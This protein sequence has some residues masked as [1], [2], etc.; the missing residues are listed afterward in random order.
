MNKKETIFVHLPAYRDPELVPTIKSALENAKYPKRIHFGVCRQ[1]HPE[2]G[3]DN[4]D[5]YK[6][7]KRFNIYECLYTEAKGLPWAR[8]VINEQLMGDQDYILQLDSH[9]RFAK[10][11]DVTLIEMHNQREKQGYKPIL[12]AYLPLYTP[13]N[14]PGG[15]TMEPWQQ[16]FVCFYPHGT[17]FIRPGLLTGWQDMTEAPFSRFLSGHFC[18]ARTEWA[19]EIKHDP[20]IY[21]SGEEINLTVR[22]YTHGYDMFHPHK[23]VVWH[24]TMRE[25]RSGMLKWDDDAKRGVDWWNKQNTAR[26]KIR[27]L[28]RVEDNGF[29]LTGYDLG[30]TR[31]I[32][33]YEAYAGVNFKEKSVQ[34]YTI[35]NG[36]PPTPQDSVWSKSFYHLVTI[37]RNELPADDYKS[38][39]IA[40]DDEN[41]IGIHSKTIEGHQLQQFLSGNGP[42]HFEEYFLYFNKEPKRMVAWAYSESRGWAERVEHKL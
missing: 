8:A 36:Y 15:R 9:H 32:E 41:G 12:A 14:D 3:F 4:L 21:F 39:L 22:S 31:T 23:L 1:Y 37:H 42:I 24:S 13:F 38:I 18:F 25:E 20:D 34:K 19:R 33:D 35:D 27:Q 7:D 28:F 11:W 29:D 10:D 2:D 26:A 5:E 30:T 17:I 40:F 6:N 16:H